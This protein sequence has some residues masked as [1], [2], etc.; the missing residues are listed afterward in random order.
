[1]KYLLLISCLILCSCPFGEDEGV[2]VEPNPSISDCP[3]GDIAE[4]PISEPLPPRLGENERPLIGLCPV[5][6]KVS[7]KELSFSAKGG[8]RCVTTSIISSPKGD[9]RGC[10]TEFEVVSDTVNDPPHFIDVNRFKKEVCPWLIAMK[11]DE[12]VIYISVDKNETGNERKMFMFTEAGNCH[13]GF[14]IT[15]SAE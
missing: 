6:V 2:S 9:A 10:R 12:R 5:P 14:T 7:V 15:Q 1:M 8:V 13:G 3:S 4:Y 11:A